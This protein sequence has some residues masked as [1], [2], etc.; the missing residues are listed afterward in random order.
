[1]T[2]SSLFSQEGIDVGEGRRNLTYLY[3]LSDFF[4]FVFE[5]TETLNLLMEANAVSASEVYS[6]FLQMTSSFSLEDVQTHTLS[7]ISLVLLKESDRLGTTTKYKINLPISKV[8]YLA[9]RPFLPSQILE[10]EV[11]FRLIQED[12]ESCV[13]QFARPL[14]EY[15]FSRR[16]SSQGEEV[17]I[18]AVDALI[19]DQLMYT[20][21]G[22]LVGITPQKSSEAFSNFIYGLYFL[23]QNGPTL[24][25]MERG[26]NLLLGIPLSR[27]K[28]VVIDIRNYLETDN[29]LIITDSNQYLL[30]PGVTP[31]IRVGETLAVG[32]SLSKWVEL[33]DHLTKEDWWINI[34]IP[35]SIIRRI[36]SGQ[37]T[38]IAEAGSPFDIMFREYLHKNTFLIKINVNIL[39]SSSYVED[40]DPLVNKIKPGYTSPLYVWKVEIDEDSFGAEEDLLS[41]EEEASLMTSINSQPIDSQAI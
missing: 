1:M 32:Q 21:F 6:K 19:D 10:S 40:I 7:S 39:S 2:P 4:S 33:N 24:Q 17:A 31:S 5:D 13:V 29:Y 26:L 36:P 28:E 35:R 20:H 41:I 34:S 9:N 25:V 14:S 3:G 16:V 30:P 22:K 8:K 27:K 23:Y 11:D 37:Q 12:L 38:R 15:S 18:W